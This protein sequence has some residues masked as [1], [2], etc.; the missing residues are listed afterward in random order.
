MQLNL[1]NEMIR[2]LQI[3]NILGINNHL[4]RFKL[5]DPTFGLIPLIWSWVSDLLTFPLLL[6]WALLLL[7][8]LPF[9]S[10]FFRFC[11]FLESSS[12]A[13]VVVAM[14]VWMLRGWWC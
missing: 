1:L 4:A 9:S 6:S 11:P 13:T 7:L 3:N 5:K 10:S 14:M 8:N 2:T 12:S